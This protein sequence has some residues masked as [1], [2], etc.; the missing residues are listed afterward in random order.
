MGLPWERQLSTFQLFDPG[1]E[2]GLNT[3]QAMEADKGK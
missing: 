2:L 3:A 1:I